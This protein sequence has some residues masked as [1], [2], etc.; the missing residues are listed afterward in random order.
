MTKSKL[1]NCYFLPLSDDWIASSYYYSQT[2]Y[3]SRRLKPIMPQSRTVTAEMHPN[4]N[5]MLYQSSST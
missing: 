4:S 3:I 2:S 1:Y 5:I